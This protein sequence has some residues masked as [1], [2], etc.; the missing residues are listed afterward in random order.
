MSRRNRMTR[1]LDSEIA[2]HIERETEINIERGMPAEEARYAALR[3][4]G[5]VTRVK[6]E[7]REVWSVVWLDQLLQ[8]VRVGL[9][10]LRHNP[11]FTAV[12]TLT[13]ALGIA[14]NTYIFTM[15]DTLVLHPMELRDP[16]RTVAVWERVPSAGVERNELSPANFLDWQSQSHAFDHIAAQSWWEVN[17]GGVDRPEHLHGFQV[18]SDYFAALQAQPM[19]GRTFLPEEGVAGKNHVAV[20]SYSLWR[21]R[22][23]SDPAITGRSV[24]LNSIPYT[25]IGVMG[26]NFSYP[27]GA[28]IWGALAFTPDERTNRGFHYLHGVAHLAPGVTLEQARAELG[29]IAARLAQRYPESNT[30]REANLIPL[31]DSEVSRTRML[32]SVMLVA[33]GL[34]LLIACANI[35]NLLLA[36][37][38]A[39]QRETAIR[40]ALGAT[41]FRLLRQ[42]LVESL[43]LGLLGGALG[44][45]IVYLGLQIRL[46]H[47][48]AEFSRMILGWQKVAINTPVLLFTLAVSLGTGLLFGLLPA[49]GVSRLN[50]NDALKEGTPAAG[51]GRRRGVLR[52]VLI[53]AE[54]ALSLALLVT[55]GLMM[56]SFVRLQSVSPGFNP[57]K[58][59]TM[60]ISLP[61]TQY[62]SN[63]Q[64][65]NFYEQLLSRVQALPGVQNAAAANMLPLAGANMT[66]AIRIDGA[67]EPKPGE[68]PQANFRTVSDSYFGAMQVPLLRGREFSAQDSAASLPVVAVNQAFAAHFWPG[69]DAIGKRMRCDGDLRDN[70][71]QTV[72]AVV[73]NVRNDLD[74]AASP[75]MYFPLR[76]QP[77]AGM[78]LIVRSATDPHSLVEPIR[79]E[80]AA[81]DRNLPVFQVLTMDDWRS[82]SVIGQKL[83]GMLMSSFAVFALLLAAT[84]LF[85]VI[86]YHVT[87]R[88][89][90]IGIRIALGA[91]RRQIMRLVVGEGMLLTLIGLPVGLA[92]AIAMGRAISGLLYGV[93][94]HDPATLLGVAAVLVVVAF[95]ACYIPARRAMRV[96][97]IAALRHE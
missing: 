15:V 61:E 20:F 12:V 69:Q 74:Q 41:R 24:L 77:S 65:T 28:E 60:S 87:E 82:F 76:Q 21:D 43:L 90:E 92:L 70:P 58:L 67:P 50:V 8:D 91:G 93:K 49:L 26:P 5:N 48:P 19:I 63:P 88:T 55:A 85:G 78:S 36:R 89:R 29:A 37:A 53:V 62:A 75:E 59:L 10:M 11:G 22:F 51:L 54:V 45:F 46:I 17:L 40:T 6:E 31:V 38:R 95:V 33:V 4:F 42:W 44:I 47:V 52:S 86:A 23:A 2:D 94:P 14:A 84:G 56:Q 34:V 3:K 39:R 16:Q 80:L 64:I 73:G 18:T 35:S 1:D 72:V 79:A 30:G 25:V 9:R 97:P 13:L 68:V 71:W 7:V 32:L 27:S 96:D 66:R 83:G 57:D 81:L